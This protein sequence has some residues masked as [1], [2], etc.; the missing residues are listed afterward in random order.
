MFQLL[1]SYLCKKHIFLTPYI[2]RE[3]ERRLTCIITG[4]TLFGQ[5][6]RY[7]PDKVGKQKNQVIKANCIVFS[8]IG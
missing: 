2:T 4:A 1:L 7:N 6:L 5:A 8:L 3:R